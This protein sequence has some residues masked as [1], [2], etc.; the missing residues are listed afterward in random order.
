[1]LQKKESLTFVARITRLYGS[2]GEVVLKLQDSFPLEIEL[3][4]P[5]FVNVDKLMVPFYIKSFTFKG[6]DKA[7]VV[8]DDLESEHRISEFLGC[9]LSMRNS[10]LN[11]DSDEDE[12]L[13]E[14]L[15][16]YKLFDLSSHRMGEITDYIDNPNN[17]IF[18]VYFDKVEVLVPANDDI[19]GDIYIDSNVVEATVPEGLYEFYLEHQKQ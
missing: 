3:E 13:F 15:V 1:M 8:F 6:E 12:L 2:K 11:S 17:P 18:V 14:D 5:L 19:I 16:G 4:E 9:E 7:V 10:A